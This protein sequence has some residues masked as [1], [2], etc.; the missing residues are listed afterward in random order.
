MSETPEQ[1]LHPSAKAV[2][3]AVTAH[4]SP[5]RP[6]V[7]LPPNLAGNHDLCKTFHDFAHKFFQSAK[8]QTERTEYED[9]LNSADAM[10]RMTK[11]SQQTTKGGANKDHHQLSNDSSSQYHKSIRLISRGQTAIIFP[12]NDDLLPAEYAPLASSNDYTPAEGKRVAE[13]RNLYLARVWGI[14]QWTPEFKQSIERTNKNGVEHFTIEWEY[15]TEKR[16]EKVPG[17]YDASGN[18]QEAKVEVPVPEGSKDGNGDPVISVFNEE[19]RPTSYVF[20]EKTRVVQNCPIVEFPRARNVFYD[21]SIDDINKQTAVHIEYFPSF[22]E[23]MAKQQDGEYLNV[24]DLS[25]EQLFTQEVDSAPK[26]DRDDNAEYSGSE[27]TNGLYHGFKAQVLAPIVDWDDPKK[28]KWDDSAVP[29]LF[30]AVFV[31]TYGSMDDSST[32]TDKDGKKRTGGAICT[33]LRHTP[34]HHGRFTLHKVHSHPDGERGAIHLSYQTLLECNVEEQTVTLRQ[35]IDNKTLIVKAPWIGEKGNVLSR[36]LKFREGNQALWV[37][38][39]TGATALTR[40]EVPDI[41]ASTIPFLDW[42]SRD[43]DDLL[44][45]TEAFR[46]VFAGSRTT[47]TEYTGARDQSMKP[48][49]EDAKQ[50]AI[51]YFEPVLRDVADLCDQFAPNWALKEGIVANELYGEAEVRITS[52]EKYEAD[53]A[54]QQ[55]LVNFIQSGGYDKARASG[56]MSKEGDLQFWRMVGEHLKMPEYNAIFDGTRQYVEAENQALAD[57]QAIM[58]DPLGSMDNPELLPKPGEMHN[59][60]TRILEQSKLKLQIQ[61]RTLQAEDREINAQQI[62]ALELY[63]AMHRQLQE[64]ETAQQEQQ[65]AAA[66]SGQNQS[67]SPPEL[68]GEA[69]GDTLSGLAGQ[70]TPG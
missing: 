37:Q 13:G 27:H 29:Q 9:D 10:W 52:V 36:D 41:T 49:L 45:T 2:D 62:A 25:A 32:A 5:E 24:G 14:N 17:Y 11:K 68:A 55:V 58:A 21:L 53:L 8:D 20:I 64:E 50:M 48:A 47:G 42:L 57:V 63:I 26:T 67:D 46:G 43:A 70:A 22:P 4:D 3:A 66:A 30:E 16:I 54:A 1:F 69:Q 44:G 56:A 40:L 60:H 19:G 39:G 28:A 31:G 61:G 33:Q 6:Y 15:R 65:Q 12:N 51:Q 23:L 38:P 34:Y 59:I 18:P 35:H 7:K